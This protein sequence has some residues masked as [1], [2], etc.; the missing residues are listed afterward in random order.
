M[1][2][3]TNITATAEDG[4]CLSFGQK[5]TY[6][7]GQMAVSLSPALISSWLIFFY[8]GRDIP[9]PE[10]QPKQTLFLVTAAAM[11][12]GGLIPRLLEA[13]AEPVVG[14]LSDK[15]ATRWGRRIPWIA[16]GTP[17]LM[18]F[19]VLIFFPPD[20]N[21]LGSPLF[22]FLGLDVTPNVIWLLVTHTG[23]WCMYTA[24]VAP[25]LSLLPE[26]TPY[27]NERIKVSEF[28]AYNDV[29]GT[30]AGAIGL[31]LMI[32][33][34]PNGLTIGPLRTG[35]AFEAS[36]FIVG[37]IFFASFYLSISKVREKPSTEIKQVEFH[38]VQAMIETFKNPTF[39]TYVTMSAAIRM[40]TDII[41]AAMPFLVAKLMGLEEGLAGILQ[42]VIV[43]GAAVL[44]PF[45]S[46]YAEKRGKKRVMN[47]GLLWFVLWL[48][49]LALAK[50]FPFFGYPAAWVALLFGKTMPAAWVSFAHCIV[51]LAACA[52][53]VSIIFVLQRPILT[54]V[55][56]HDE[57]LTGYRREAMYNGMEGLIS[58]PASGLAYF[59]VPL[60]F[61][62]LGATEEQPWGIVAA[63]IVGGII[64][65][66]GWAVFRRYPIEK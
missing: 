48:G 56:D 58:K 41:L 52:L 21:S 65:L 14:H 46:R 7:L 24:V 51:C 38:F 9:G 55:I 44:F 20:R 59:I 12:L 62:W 49:V 47:F 1:A 36:G 13:V 10:G 22:S 19:S 33:A 23:F 5:F 37:M 39:P 53:S 30:A 45:V 64:L 29:L 25:Y 66:V 2:E 17:L 16:F 43:I 50:H 32:N 3:I 54:D 57:T 15:H 11:S 8:T 40:G 60:L 18:L 4:S 34:L 61:A 31:G 27:N 63:P 35:N 6:S 28:M 26:I 42:G